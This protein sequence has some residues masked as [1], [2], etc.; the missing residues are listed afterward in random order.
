MP[1][2]KKDLTGMPFGRL[3]A[4]EPTDERYR[5]NV[6][7]KCQC[8]CEN[9]TIVYRPSSQLL[10]GD[11]NSCGCLKR[12]QDKINLT[13]PKDGNYEHLREAFQAQKIDGV[14]VQFFTDTPNGNNTSGYKGVVKKG[15]NNWQARIKVN[16]K[17]YYKHG[18]KTAEEA[19]YKGRL[20]LEKEHLPKKE[21]RKI[22]E[23]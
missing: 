8:S 21:K 18:F 4:L 5:G 2:A 14:A 16:G 15:R 9:K 20:V 6:V 3:T 22:N 7:W 10:D 12:D 17:S 23:I 13:G 1:N 11:I 19:Y